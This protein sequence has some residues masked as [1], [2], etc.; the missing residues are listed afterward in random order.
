M[1]VETTGMERGQEDAASLD[2]IYI[3]KG[4]NGTIAA[5]SSP[6]HAGAMR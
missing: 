5:I 4:H 6:E 1:R 3:I 2:R